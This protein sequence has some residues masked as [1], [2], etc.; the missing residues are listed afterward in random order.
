MLFNDNL[1]LY[2]SPGFQSVRKFGFV[3][4]WACG[5]HLQVS[6]MPQFFFSVKLS[7]FVR[8]EEIRSER[9]NGKE[10]RSIY[11]KLARGKV[12]MFY[13]HVDSDCVNKV[14]KSL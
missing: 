6:R 4:T 12:V 5:Q 10:Q 11:Y 7:A 13:G 9:P 14:T 1:Q 8:T 2:Q 3:R